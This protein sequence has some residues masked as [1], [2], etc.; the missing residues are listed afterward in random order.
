MGL[1]HPSG[2]AVDIGGRGHEPLGASHSVAIAL[3]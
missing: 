2:D 3:R 1:E